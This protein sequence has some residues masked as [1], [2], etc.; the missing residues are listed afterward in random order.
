MARWRSKTS[1]RRRHLPPS[2]IS[3]SPPARPPSTTTFPRTPIRRSSGRLRRASAV[4][5]RRSAAIARA[6][7]GP[8]R[9]RRHCRCGCNC[10]SRAGKSSLR[11]GRAAT[12]PTSRSTARWCNRPSRSASPTTPCRSAHSAVSAPRAF[13]SHRRTSPPIRPWPRPSRRL[14]ASRSARCWQ[15]PRRSRRSHAHPL[16]PQ[17][18]PTRLPRTSNMRSG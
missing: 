18:A 6:R 12:A 17:P 9:V 7:S 1:R 16:R 8:R 11:R 14:A 4:S 2:R 3:R 13:R 5:P 10:A 15:P